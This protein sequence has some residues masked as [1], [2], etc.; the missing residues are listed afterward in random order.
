MNVTINPA[1]EISG[2]HRFPADPEL[3][4]FAAALATSC[5]GTTTI[6][7]WPSTPELI[8]LLAWL[9]E[10]GVEIEKADDTIQIHGRSTDGSLEQLSTLPK[11]NHTCLGVVGGLC[12]SLYRRC[13][14]ATLEPALAVTELDRLFTPA[15]ID[16]QEVDGSIALNPRENTSVNISMNS[17]LSWPKDAILLRSIFTDTPC[18]LTL[19]QPVSDLLERILPAYNV[20]LATTR[21]PRQLSRREQLLQ[22]IE[23]AEDVE[24]FHKRI[25]LDAGP[26]D[27]RPVDWAL[28]GDFSRAA[29]LIAATAVRPGSQVAVF[30]V[31]LDSSRTGILKVLKRMGAEIKT[32][33]RRSENGIAVGEIGVTGATLKATKVSS[34]E[35]HSLV[36]H[37][38]LLAVVAGSAIGVTVIRGFKEL[39]DLGLIPLHLV[40]A[41]LRSM[42]VKVAEL[43]DG[44]AIEGPTEWKAATLDAARHPVLAAAWEVAALNGDG[45]STITNTDARTSNLL[46]VVAR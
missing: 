31:A 9:A 11:T 46:T 18:E 24:S 20:S 15:G 16:I 34:A 25:T 43:A 2:E 23:R 1:P 3:A 28:P 36:P 10:H 22:G 17:L 45:P 7:N 6:N 33:K 30:D 38:P 13:A 26:Q 32:A 35:I 40:T 5:P 29:L 27:V 21:P 39:I 37:L 12:R 41:G 44:W 8:A 14:I 19:E 4:G 42:G